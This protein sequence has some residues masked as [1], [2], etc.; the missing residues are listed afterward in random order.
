MDKL[1]PCLHSVVV[2][3][4]SGMK[5]REIADQLCKPIGTIKQRIWRA[6]NEYGQ[7]V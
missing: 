2:L 4:K 1:P 6:R 5:Y 7:S 3:R